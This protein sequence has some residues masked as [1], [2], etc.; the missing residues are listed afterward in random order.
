MAKRFAR[1]HP[2]LA[3]DAFRILSQDMKLIKHAQIDLFAP[4]I[5]SSEN[6]P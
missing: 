4:D 3:I 6:T 2:E 1:I 5:A